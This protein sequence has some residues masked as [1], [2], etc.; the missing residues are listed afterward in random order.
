MGR[1]PEDTRK[2]VFFWKMAMEFL[3]RQWEAVDFLVCGNRDVV[4]KG[5]SWWEESNSLV[6]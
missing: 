5:E 6:L 3:I 1:S 4:F 2:V